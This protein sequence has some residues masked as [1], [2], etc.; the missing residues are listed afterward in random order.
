MQIERTLF[1]KISGLGVALALSAVMHAGAAS[2]EIIW[3]GDLES[4]DFRNFQR[5]DELGNLSEVFWGVPAYGRPPRYS[6]SQV[7][8]GNGELLSIVRRTASGP[9]KAGPVR[10]GDYAVRFAVKNSGSGSEP[11]D[12]GEGGNCRIRRSQLWTDNAHAFHYQALPSMSERWGSLSIYLQED[13]DITDSGWAPIFNSYKPIPNTSASGIFQV[14][15]DSNGWRLVYRWS[16]DLNPTQPP[17]QMVMFADAIS[18][19]G[20]ADLLKDLPDRQA[21]EAAL[22]DLNKGGWTDWVWHIKHDHR[23]SADGGTGF[24]RVWKRAGDGPWVEVLHVEPRVINRGGKVFDRGIGYNLTSD[25][26]YGISY[27]PYLPKSRIW[28]AS[29]DMVVYMDNMKIGSENADFSMMSPDGSTP[30]SFASETEGRPKPPGRIA[31]A[32]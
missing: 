10:V 31:I 22:A 29:S 12:C 28:G 26:Q 9:Y 8:T 23:G 3:S 19:H 32:N 6:D 13:F 17:W 30:Y 4:G 2:G 24:L 7:H 18:S 5:S 20:N 21:S 15:V 16:P 1:S 14:A 11:L 25:R 27:G